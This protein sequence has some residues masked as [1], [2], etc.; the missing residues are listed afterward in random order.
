MQIIA[1]SEHLALFVT[2]NLIFSMSLSGSTDSDS[3][4]QIDN[5]GMANNACSLTVLSITVFHCLVHYCCLISQLS[6][7]LSLIL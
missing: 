2:E 6:L 4:A 3:R 1:N 7:L 5:F